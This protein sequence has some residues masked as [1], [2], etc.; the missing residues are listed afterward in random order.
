MPGSVQNDE[1]PSITI[2]ASAISSPPLTR[3]A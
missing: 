1:L 2:V 3:W